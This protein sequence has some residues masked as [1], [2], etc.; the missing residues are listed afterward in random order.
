MDL[1]PVQL[2]LLALPVLAYK[3]IGWLTCAY[4]KR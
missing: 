3:V 4:T 1:S 2:F